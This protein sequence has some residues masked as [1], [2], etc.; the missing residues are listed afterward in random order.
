MPNQTFEL[1]YLKLKP[2]TD[3]TTGEDKAK[4]NKGGNILTSQPGCN[5]FFYGTQIEYPDTI[6][7][8]I[9]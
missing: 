1:V 3:I 8:V 6:Q 2:G 4:W 9:S 5:A 7:F